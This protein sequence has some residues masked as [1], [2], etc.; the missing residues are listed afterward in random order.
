MAAPFYIE[1]VQ[2]A[3]STFT[4]SFK[5]SKREEKMTEKAKQKDMLKGST[6]VSVQ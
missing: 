2:R 4:G 5:K 1:K 3:S 6:T